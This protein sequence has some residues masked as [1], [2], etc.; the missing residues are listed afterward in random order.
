MPDLPA[1]IGSV[2]VYCASSDAADPAYMEAAAAFGKA[3]AQEGLRLVYGG[4]NIGLM[5]ACAR[6]AHGAGGKVLGVMPE[7]LR[8]REI[9]YGDVE[10]IVVASMHERKMVMFEQA[11]AFVVLPGGVGTL[12]E[13][14]EMMS[15]RRLEVHRKPIVFHSPH[16]FWEPLYALF[17][18]TVDHNLTPAAF[19]D[20]WR[21]VETVEAILPALREL[22]AA[23]GPLLEARMP[24]IPSDQR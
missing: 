23:D 24:E 19:M 6:A 7:F 4:G 5:G 8:Q 11:D 9:L 14:I 15:W 22:A 13:A 2:C 20:T 18:H 21:S 10:T 3:L 1:S 12:E 16:G 17:Q